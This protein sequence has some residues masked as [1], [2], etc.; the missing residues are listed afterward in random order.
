MP[1]C[2]ICGKVLSEEKIAWCIEC[3]KPLC[4]ACASSGLCSECEEDWKSE[5]DLEDLE[6]W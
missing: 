4:L 5:E 2:G 3:G 6:E 1:V